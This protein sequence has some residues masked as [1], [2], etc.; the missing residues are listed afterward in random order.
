MNGSLAPF[1]RGTLQVAPREFI[2]TSMAHGITRD[3]AKALLRH[4]L[5]DE[6]WIN[7]EYQVNIDKNSRHGFGEMTVWWLSIKRRD[8]QPIHDWRDLQAIKTALCGP[9]VEAIELYPAESRVMDTANQYHLFALMPGPDGVAPAVPCGWPT[10][11][12]DDNPGMNAVQ[13]P[14][15]TR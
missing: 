2:R 12:R 5:A 15:S 3:A 6:V 1:V 14:G 13:R 10:G 8:K 11:E 4:I 9:E 7:D